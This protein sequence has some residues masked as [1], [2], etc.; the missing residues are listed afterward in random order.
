MDWAYKAAGLYSSTGQ[1]DV[2][3]YWAEEKLLMTGGQVLTVMKDK[4]YV[5]TPK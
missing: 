5:I 2:T 1:P 4:R 3:V